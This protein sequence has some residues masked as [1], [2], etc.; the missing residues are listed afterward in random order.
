MKKKS[1]QPSRV[2]LKE[3]EIQREIIK[4]LE[5]SG[6]LVIKLI[7]TNQNGI[8]DLLCIKEGKTVF[9]EVKAPYRTST[10]LQLYMQKRITAAGADVFETNNPHFIL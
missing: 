9:I 10:P 4:N 3:S 2:L 6:W 1:P 5:G 7:Q 8:P